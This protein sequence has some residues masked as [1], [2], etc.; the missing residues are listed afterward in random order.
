M[1]FGRNWVVGIE[2]VVP[3]TGDLESSPSS[4][5][6]KKTLLA[7]LFGEPGLDLPKGVSRVGGFPGFFWGEGG[8][9]ARQPTG[10]RAGG[11][12]EGG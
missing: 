12:G 11:G 8:V 5:K 1:L 9:H 3:L 7:L 2:R 4:K 10:W 6:K